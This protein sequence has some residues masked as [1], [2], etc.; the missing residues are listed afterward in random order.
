M[1]LWTLRDGRRAGFALMTFVIISVVGCAG[2]DP[3]PV[4][5]FPE[6]ACANC[7]MAVSS[8]QFASE[9]ITTKGKVHKFDDINCLDQFSVRN[10][11]EKSAATYYMDYDTRQWLRAGE[12]TI[13]TTGISTPMGS[14]KVAVAD[15]KRAEE[16]CGQ[17]PS[18]GDK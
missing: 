10:P 6:D 12:C 18:S 14:G 7:R 13:V 8:K 9:I 4:E 2:K 11:E 16:L 5:I 15:V 1:R 3:Q 17:F